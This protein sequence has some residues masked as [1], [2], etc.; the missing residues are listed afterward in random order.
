[1]IESLPVR[2]FFS[3]FWR[4]PGFVSSVICGEFINVFSWFRLVSVLHLMVIK[5]GCFIQ[6]R[7]KCPPKMSL[8]DHL[9][10]THFDAF[11]RI[12][13]KNVIFCAILLKTAIFIVLRLLCWITHCGS[14]T[15]YFAFWSVVQIN[16][17]YGLE[18]L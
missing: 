14:K 17:N 10:K 3:D 7:H 4:H 5:Y 6:G 9:S 18:F 16:P 15:I 13:R 2:T 11:R 1:M 8:F 12:D